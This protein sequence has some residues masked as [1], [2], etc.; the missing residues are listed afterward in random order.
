MLEN[1]L[2]ALWFFLPAGFGNAAP[3]FVAKLPFVRR[4]DAPIDRGLHIRGK[5]LLGAHK[6]WRGLIAGMIA[7]TA[8]LWL[9]QLI[10]RHVGWTH[11]FVDPIHGYHELPVLLLGPLL[12]FGALAGDAVESFFKRQR[13]TAPGDSWFPFDQIDYI[14]GAALASLPVVTMNL[15]VYLWAF[16]AWPTIHVVSS[17]I[18][19]IVGLKEKPI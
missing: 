10:V 8:V 11:V 9:Q 16:I 19:Y 5:R 12:G 1:I 7:A 13:G 4:F 3:I 2:C 6:T 15:Y 17:G 18:G 14:I